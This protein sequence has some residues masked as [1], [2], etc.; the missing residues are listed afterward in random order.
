MSDVTDALAHQQ[1]L[2]KI[3]VGTSALLTV[4]FHF[5][6]FTFLFVVCSHYLTLS[7]LKSLS[8]KI[9]LFSFYTLPSF[10]KNMSQEG[11]HWCIY[12]RFYPFC[13]TGFCAGF[14]IQKLCDFFL[15]KMH[16][17]FYCSLMQWQ[18]IENINSFLKYFLLFVCL[19]QIVTLIKK[20][21]CWCS[22][23]CCT[24]I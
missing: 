6:F 5:F 16:F 13:W 20:C 8:P 9:S 19:W 10:N 23:S 14:C 7:L 4:I 2:K 1:Q 22:F 15:W 18:L 24:W 11:T 3:N 17:F 21:L 12:C